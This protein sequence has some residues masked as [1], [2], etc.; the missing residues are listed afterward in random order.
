MECG[1][2][3]WREG[4]LRKESFTLETAVRRPQSRRKGAITNVHLEAGVASPRARKEN[5]ACYRN[6]DENDGRFVRRQFS[7]IVMAS[8]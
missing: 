2:S 3:V 5:C 7:R 1:H 4:A 6:D 8:K